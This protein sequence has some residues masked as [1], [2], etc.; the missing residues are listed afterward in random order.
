MATYE[1][2][3]SVE[4]CGAITELVQSMSAHRPDVILCK[5]CLNPAPFKLSTPAIGTDGMSNAP[6]DAVVGRE[7]E[8]RWKRINSRQEQ[9][10]QVRRE[11]GSQGLAATSH[12]TFVPISTKQRV[13]RTRALN[14]VERDGHK[15]DA[16]DA[17][18]RLVEAGK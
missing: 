10:N 11:A 17:Q 3:C 18:A 14:E 15:P 8:A 2:K 7:S 13:A 9:R 1:Y 12:D 4:G 5:F 6:I 16:S